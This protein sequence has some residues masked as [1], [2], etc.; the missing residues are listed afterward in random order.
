MASNWA[1]SRPTWARKN[2][3][4]SDI[5]VLFTVYGVTVAIGSW[6]AG[7][8][9]NIWGPRRVM[10]LGAAI[11]VV[12]EIFFLSL[13]VGQLSYP[14]MI[15]GYALR[16]FG[17]PLF[18]Y[19]FLVWIVAATP[20]RKLGV[21]MGWFWVA[22]AAGLPTPGALVASFTVPMIGALATFWLSLVLV[23]AG[24]L[25]ALLCVKDAAGSQR[26]APVAKSR[27]RP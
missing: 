17:Y 19:G 25:M 14:M 22:Y 5:A 12:F 1:T 6:C 15:A 11:W 3:A 23:I 16:G 9:S 27:W 2:I 21:A 4:E 10:W 18:A 24:A 26:L 7:A 20:A 8:L 13:G